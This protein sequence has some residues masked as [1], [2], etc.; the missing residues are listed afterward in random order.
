MHIHKHTGEETPG[1][2]DR[3]DRD[4]QE[5]LGVLE[6]AE[7]AVTNLPNIKSCAHKTS[8]CTFKN[9]RGRSQ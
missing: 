6:V 3:G 1:G 7:G 8:T 9:V 2:T 5:I 4:T